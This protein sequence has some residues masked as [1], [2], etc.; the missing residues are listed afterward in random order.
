MSLIYVQFIKKNLQCKG[1][2]DYV[3]YSDQMYRPSKLIQT[4]RRYYRSEVI[5]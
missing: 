5:R 1:L 4:V 2:T 3:L